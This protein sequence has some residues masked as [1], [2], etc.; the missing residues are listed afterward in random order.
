MEGLMM[1]QPSLSSSVLWRTERLFQDKKTVS[2]RA[3]RDR[4]RSPVTA[5]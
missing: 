1:D 4:P 2:F 3:G 5:S